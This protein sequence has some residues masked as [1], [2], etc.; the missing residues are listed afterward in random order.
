MLYGL[1]IA[2]D[3]GAR[4]QDTRFPRPPLQHTARG[5]R[6]KEHNCLGCP[7]QA[8]AQECTGAIRLAAATTRLL[9]LHLRQRHLRRREPEG[10]VHGAIHLDGS[11][12][13]SAG[14]LPLAGL[15]I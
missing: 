2:Y 14:L 5:D 3:R 8:N 10:H 15:G 12:Q 13:L 11:G 4:L 1:Q 6:G 7:Q 9:L